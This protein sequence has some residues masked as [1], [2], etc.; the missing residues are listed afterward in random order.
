MYIYVF[1]YALDYRFLRRCRQNYDFMPKNAEKN[2]G[3]WHK[4]CF[5]CGKTQQNL[6]NLIWEEEVVLFLSAFNI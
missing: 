3:V 5:P 2:I 4:K 1:T 6:L